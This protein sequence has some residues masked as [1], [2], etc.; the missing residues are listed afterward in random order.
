MPKIT[1]TVPGKPQGKARP[2]FCRGHA[3]TPQKTREYEA[4][5]ALL[6]RRAARGESFMNGEALRICVYAY[7][8][9]PAKAK[10]ADTAEMQRGD[11]LPLKKPDIDNVVK[12]IL[13]ALNGVAYRDDTQVAELHAAK[14]YS[15]DPRVIVTLE[16]I[17]K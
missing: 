9:I 7:Y 2:R 16:T 17:G 5:A 8:P 10:I 1:F 14:H 3:V 15:V 11:L 6:Y 12:I 4:A 13:D